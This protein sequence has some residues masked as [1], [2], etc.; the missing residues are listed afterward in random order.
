EKKDPE[1]PAGQRLIVISVNAQ[2]ASFFANGLLVRQGP[3][4]TGTKSHPTPMGVFSVLQKNKHHVSNLYGAAMPFMQRLTWSGTALHTGPLPGY[5]ASHGCVRMTNDFAQMLWG[6]TRIGARVIVTREET[7]PFEIEHPRLFAPKPAS[8]LADQPA[9]R[10][11]GELVKT[12]SADGA[13]PDASARRETIG[14]GRQADAATETPAAAPVL[15][16]KEIERRKSPV[17]VFVSRK[18]GRLYVRQGMEP[19]FDTP[20]TIREPAAVLGTHVFTAMELKN[21]GAAMRWT[22]V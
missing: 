10:K 20:V 12:A 3:V 11:A 7:A 4:S 6:Q 9:I 18:E 19:V 17:S 14:A 15:S 5:P 22:V 13:M 16:A 21:D 2:R 1:I 8:P